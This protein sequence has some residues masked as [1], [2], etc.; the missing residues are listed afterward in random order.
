MLD[1][2]F[3]G[4]EDIIGSD[5]SKAPSELNKTATTIGK[6]FRKLASMSMLAI[7]FTTIEVGYIDALLS[8]IADSVGGKYFTTE[9]LRY[10]YGLAARHLPYII[11]GLGNPQTSDWMVAAM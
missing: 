7:N 1:Y 9:D 3:Y 6:K 8:A 11:A 10:G 4:K 2:R 5:Q